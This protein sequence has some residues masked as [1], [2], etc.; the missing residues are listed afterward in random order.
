MESSQGRGGEAERK[1][2]ERWEEREGGKK[3]QNSI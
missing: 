3:R 1:W 2:E